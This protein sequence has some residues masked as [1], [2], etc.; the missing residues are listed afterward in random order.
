[1]SEANP[2]IVS[3]EWL[4]ARLDKP[5]MSIVDA[6]W[7]LPTAN[8]N[9]REEYI[10]AHIP[11]AV[12]FDQ[13]LVCDSLSPLPHTLPAPAEF[14]RHASAMGITT[15]DTIV[16]YDGNGFF[17][18][19]RVWWMF[20]IMGAKH[21]YVLDGGFK[22]WLANNYPVTDD[23]TQVAPSSFH[24]KF[25]SAALMSLD[26]M[27]QVVA[28]KALQ[29]ADA[30]AN[31][32]FTGA[33]VEPRAGIRSGHMPG[34]RNIPATELSHNGYFKSID[35]IRNIF[36]NAGID[37]DKPVVASCG[38]GVTAAVLVLGLQSLG[39]SNV[40]LYDGSWTEWGSL[41]DSPIET[42]EAL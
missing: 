5:G 32:R 33:E 20:R 6:S 27:R 25:Q 15:D 39:N 28:A 21:V 16:V 12:F 23:V 1:M 38:S 2:F 22:G 19:P 14:A 11:G 7:Y 10:T 29:I 26:G 17:S 35:D 4:A 41:A 18:A 13:D 37:P 24:A 40:Q 9:A 8:R 31:G 30:R 36:I 34:A 42:G 3:A